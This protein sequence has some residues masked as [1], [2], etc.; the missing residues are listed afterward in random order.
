MASSNPTGSNKAKIAKR[1]IEVLEF[2][3][4]SHPQATVMDIVRRFD[5]PQSSTSELLSSLVDVGLLYKDPQSRSYSP[6]PRA[7]MLGCAA[8][9]SVVRDGRL[10]GLIDRLSAQT[11]L[12]V[13]VFGMVGLKV[14]V[15]TWREGQRPLRTPNPFAISGGQK[16]HLTDSAAGRLLLSTIPQA[17]RE[18]MLRRLNAEACDERKFPFAEMAGKLQQCHVDGQVAG[19]AGFGTNAQVATVLFPEQPAN[20]PL[21]IGFVYDASEQV[22]P[23]ALLETLNDAVVRCF[24]AESAAPAILPPVAESTGLASAVTSRRPEWMPAPMIANR[25]PGM[26]GERAYG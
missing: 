12:A 8:Q 21:A 4:E 20:Q 10:T 17:R 23:T 22:D 26:P 24:Y 2:F 6:T 18:S 15:Y 9:P 14:Q 19:A 1:V 13:A 11:G 3:D 25:R 7:A 5:R 16:E